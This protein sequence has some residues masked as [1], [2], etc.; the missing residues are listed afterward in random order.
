MIFRVAPVRQ[1]LL[2]LVFLFVV[3]ILVAVPVV[4]FAAVWVLFP[5]LVVGPHAMA[6][7]AAG[8]TT[9]HPELLISGFRQ[10]LPAQLRLGGFFSPPCWWCWPPPPWPTTAAS[11]RR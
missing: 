7:I 4:G 8:G 6:R 5:A 2:N 11:R 9:P 1:L 3:T 10:N